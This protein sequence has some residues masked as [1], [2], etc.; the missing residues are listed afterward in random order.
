M[1]IEHFTPFFSE[2]SLLIRRSASNVSVSEELA[3]NLV[4]RRNSS[5]QL[6]CLPTLLTVFLPFMA[7]QDDNDRKHTIHT[8]TTKTIR[9]VQRIA[10]ISHK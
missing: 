9:F 3:A 10:I 4:T 8:H 2:F 1:V 7:T 5:T 6:A